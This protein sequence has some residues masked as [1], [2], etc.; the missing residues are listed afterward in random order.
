MLCV[1]SALQVTLVCRLST[2]KLS[3]GET[4]LLAHP[5]GEICV[6]ADNSAAELGVFSQETS[7]VIKLP[8]IIAWDCTLVSFMIVGCCDADILLA[9]VLVAKNYNAMLLS[10]RTGWPQRW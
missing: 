4:P 1:F 2:R 8:L 7:D 5:F 9:V 3:S 6:L 10:P